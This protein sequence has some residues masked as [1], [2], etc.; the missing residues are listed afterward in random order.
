MTSEVA[1]VAPLISEMTEE[2][3]WTRVAS[4]CKCLTLEQRRCCTLQSDTSCV[5]KNGHNALRME[6]EGQ[7]GPIKLFKQGTAALVSR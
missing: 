6:G 4:L 5:G 3:G 7:S 2:R 1:K